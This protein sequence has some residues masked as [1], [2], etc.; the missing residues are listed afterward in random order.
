MTAPKCVGFIVR[1]PSALRDSYK[2][3][4][5]PFATV[6]CAARPHVGRGTTHSDTCPCSRASIIS[7]S[8]PES[9]SALSPCCVLPDPTLRPRAAGGRANLHAFDDARSFAARAVVAARL[10]PAGRAWR[11]H[12]Q[13]APQHVWWGPA[14]IREA[15]TPPP[16]PSHNAAIRHL[17]DVLWIARSAWWHGTPHA[18]PTGSCVPEQGQRSAR[19]GRACEFRHFLLSTWD[20][21][22]GGKCG[23]AE[24]PG[25][26]NCPGWARVGPGT[27]GR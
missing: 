7:I 25:Q 24:Q 5:A 3:H 16:T 27:W 18:G 20:D 13:P 1:Y 23:H 6:R 17:A 22:A 12:V 14:T 2:A 26:C 4:T 9:E 8:G 10:V 19:Y 21:G 15:Y 11:G